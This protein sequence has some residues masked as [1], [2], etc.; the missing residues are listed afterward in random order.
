MLRALALAFLAVAAAACGGA[1]EHASSTAAPAPT[2]PPPSADV[3]LSIQHSIDSVWPAWAAPGARPDEAVQVAEGDGRTLYFVPTRS[4]WCSALADASNVLSSA[5]SPRDG[6][7]PP[8]EASLAGD[9]RGQSSEPFGVYGWAAPT[10]VRVE[11]QFADGTSQLLP[12]SQG[13]FLWSASGP[14]TSRP[15]TL[16]ALAA[17]GSTV[18]ERPL[19][20]A[21]TWDVLHSPPPPPPSPTQPPVVDTVQMS[22]AGSAASVTINGDG[23]CGGWTMA[24]DVG[25]SESEVRFVTLGTDASG[26]ADDGGVLLGTLD[27]RPLIIG[28]TGTGAT[29]AALVLSDGSEQPVPL[30]QRCV[31]VALTNEDDSDAL[32]PTAL[33]WRDASGAAHD[34]AID[35]TWPTFLTD[36][37]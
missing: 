32:H 18:A 11:L 16:V 15:A 22:L 36:S 5:C 2:G 28:E 30:H 26:G 21:R 6:S 24:G 1:R 27:T 7:R 34:A 33:R 12:L 31:L 10:A 23:T 8:L 3:Q 19:L 17:D 9:L 25:V 4:V 37:P 13:F 29:S 20:D 14:L 35:A